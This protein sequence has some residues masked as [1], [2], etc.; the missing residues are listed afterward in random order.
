MNIPPPPAPPPQHWREHWFE[1]DRVLTLSSFDDQAAVYYDES[2]RGR[3]GWTLQFVS[4]AWRYVKSVYGDDF[5]PDGRLYAVFH[6]GHYSGGHPATHFAASHD[7]RNA[8]DCGPGPWGE[9]CEG[10]YDMPS[11]EIAHVVEFANNGVEG[12][13]AFPVWGDSK[14]AE[15]F[16]Y[17]LYVGLGMQ[18]DAARVRTD[19]LRGSDP[20]PRG[21]THWFRDWF[22]PLWQEARGP[23]V[24]VEYF[25][26]LAE[27]FPRK[28]D[29]RHYSRSMNL[30]EYVHFTSGA[31][32]RDLTYQAEIAFGRRDSW[33]AELAA[34]RRA[35]P[36]ITYRSRG[37]GSH[38]EV[39]P[40]QPPRPYR[41][42]SSAAAALAAADDPGRGGNAGTATYYG[43][44]NA[45]AAAVPA[46]LSGRI[47]PGGAR[48]LRNS[49]SAAAPQ[50]PGA[51]S[52]IKPVSANAPGPGTVR[53][54]RAASAA[55]RRVVPGST[56][57]AAVPGLPG[58]S[59]RPVRSGSLYSGLYD[60]IQLT[61][62]P[63]ETGVRSPVAGE[64]EV[65]G[66]TRGER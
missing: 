55:G 43:S 46:S 25:R 60:R 7:H 26:L 15:F 51:A 45:G 41:Q 53:A 11:H 28:G 27:W 50:T 14:W 2:V 61:G 40:P 3:T 39:G 9:E 44:G 1:H 23:D 21:G 54:K 19:F 34:A 63:P 48:D 59:V 32:G 65:G 6:Q 16:I 57:S 35:F 56:D 37:R 13:P 62:A 8:I 12:S 42:P 47:D 17:D 4:R 58:R 52:A 29:R 31:I 10:K 20:F 49:R 22:G 5:G 24:L 18:R 36:E 66:G 64:D 38:D 30:G 33:L